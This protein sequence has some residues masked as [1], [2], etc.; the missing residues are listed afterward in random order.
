MIYSP[1]LTKT[2]TAQSK[3]Y[4]EEH[5]E[6]AQGDRVRMTE[7]SAA[8]GIR[9]GDFG[10]IAAIGDTLEVRLDKGESVQLTK[11]QAK[12]IE[13]GYAV[14]SLKT[15]A[16]D[17]VLISQDDSQA[18]SEAVSLSRT[19]RQVSVYT[20]DSSAQANAVAPTIALP[21]QLKPAMPFP[22]QQQSEAPSNAIA[23][24]QAPVVQHR[25]SRGR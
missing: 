13:H 22:V 4:R 16:P 3:V 17:N 19:G 11:E 8:Q 25:H 23:P 15:G 14:D 6:F 18:T 7:A 21:E 24:E 9:K 1:H 12:H 20:S 5:Q 2:M 10:T